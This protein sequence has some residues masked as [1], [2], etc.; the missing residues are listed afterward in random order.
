[1][2]SITERRTWLSLALYLGAA[3]LL[4]IVKPA[5]AFREDGSPYP[6]GCGSGKSVFSLNPTLAALAVVSSFGVAWKELIDV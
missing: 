4:W 3:A 1:M 5:F 6:F 2:R